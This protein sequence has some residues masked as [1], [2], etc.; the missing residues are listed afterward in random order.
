MLISEGMTNHEMHRVK[1]YTQNSHE[2]AMF[3]AR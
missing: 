3:V 1:L 2:L